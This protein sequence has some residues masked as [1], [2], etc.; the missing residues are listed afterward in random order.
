MGQGR[1]GRSNS[2]Y[3]GLCLVEFNKFV[4]Y[5]AMVKLDLPYV[6]CTTNRS[7]R[8]YYSFRKKGCSRVRLPGPVGSAAFLKVY[9]QCLQASETEKSE[10]KLLIK[11][12]SMTALVREFYKKKEFLALATSTQETYRR[13]LERFCD[14]HGQKLIADLEAKHVD[15][16]LAK[17][18]KT[19]AAANQ[20][21]KRLKQVLKLAVKLKWIKTNPLNEVERIEY[22][23]NPHHTWTED[24]AKSFVKRHPVGT[25]AYLAFA[26]MV[27]TGLRKSDAVKLDKGHIVGNSIVLKHQQKTRIA[28]SIPISEELAEAFST[29]EGRKIFLVNSHGRPFTANGFGNW[30]RQRCNEAGLPQ[31][32]SHGLRKLIA[33][34]LAERGANENMISA[35]L[36]HKNNQQAALYTRAA[37]REKLNT[38]SINLLNL[39]N[40][41]KT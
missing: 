27:N 39:M 29:V 12:G 32:S 33:T 17:M 5:L 34:R 19:P 22:D 28:V 14:E 24:E 37:N 36:G 23:D 1:L 6:H 40:G 25:M 21:R 4:G 26:I 30:M 20:L 13:T 11:A 31:C 16:I 9:H 3:E 2:K 15:D 38:D 18:V 10:N 35:I 8:K 7:D 41:A